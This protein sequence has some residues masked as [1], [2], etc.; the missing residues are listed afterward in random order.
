MPNRV[1]SCTRGHKRPGR[2]VAEKMSCARSFSG[3]G[4]LLRRDHHVDP[5]MPAPRAA[6]EHH[7]TRNNS[8][9]QPAA[10]ANAA[11]IPIRAPAMAQPVILVRA[12]ACVIARSQGLSTVARV[13]RGVGVLLPDELDV[14]LRDLPGERLVRNAKVERVEPPPLSAIR[15]RASHRPRGDRAMCFLFSLLPAT[16]WVVIR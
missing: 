8:A 16:F 6:P 1:G 9:T 5:A 10:R 14:S 11:A 13:E 4:S 7:G 2:N 3:A 12:L 15:R